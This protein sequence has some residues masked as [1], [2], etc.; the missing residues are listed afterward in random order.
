MLGNREAWIPS[1]TIPGLCGEGC[2]ELVLRVGCPRMH[3][4]RSLYEMRVQGCRMSMDSACVVYAD[5]D[6]YKLIE[7]LRG[8]LQTDLRGP[9]FV[10][11]GNEIEV[12][13]NLDFDTLKRTRFP[14]GFLCFRQRIEIFPE[15]PGDGSP[16]KQVRLVSALLEGL[17]LRNVPAVAACD[18]ED[19]LPNHGGYK[20]VNIPFP[21]SRPV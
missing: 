14:D 6:R 12:V 11:S 2:G 7:A 9:C 8:I 16:E 1:A 4:P 19:L 13:E 17:W 18:Y 20:C 3:L 21:K 5:M 10:V 15:G